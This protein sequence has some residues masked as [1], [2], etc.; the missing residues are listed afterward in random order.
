MELRAFAERVVLGTTLEEKLADPGIVTDVDPGFSSPGIHVPGRPQGLELQHLEGA[1]KPP[2]EHQ[3]NSDQ[4]RGILL[5]F[6]ANHEL[7][8]T[9]LMALV[10]LKFPQA[11]AAFRQG[12]FETLKEE[13]A[14]TRLYLDRMQAC[15]VSFGALPLSG[16]FWRAVEPMESPLDFVARLSLTFEQANLDYS[17]YYAERFREAGDRETAAIL[18]AIYR[19]E[20][21]HVGH[22]LKWFRKWKNQSD[23]DWDAYRKVMHFPLSPARAKATHGDYNREGRLAA[24]LEADFI[25]QLNLY[26]QSRGRKPDVYWFHPGAEEELLGAGANATLDQVARDLESLMLPLAR[27]EDVVLMRQMPSTD[28]QQRYID[29]GLS[30]PELL[31]LT[32]DL[33][34]HPLCARKIGTFRPWA[35]TPSSEGTACALNADYKTP[36]HSSA[37][38]G[39]SW[40]THQLRAWLEEEKPGYFGGPE[41][42]GTFVHT[43]AEVDAALASLAARPCTSAIAKAELGTSGRGQRRLS[44]V[45]G[46]TPHDRAWLCTALERQ[47]GILIEPELDRLLDITL[48]WDTDPMRF[49][50][51]TRQLVTA[52][53]RYAG[54]VLG[55]PFADCPVELKRFLLA[56]GYRVLHELVD[57]LQARLEGALTSLGHRGTFGVDAMV[58]RDAAGALRIKPVV[59]INPRQTMGQVALR[60]EQH[61]AAGRT[62]H[63]RLLT[64]VQLRQ[65]EFDSFEAF[66][67]T[68]QREHPPVLHRDGRLASGVLVLADAAVSRVLL[69]VLIVGETFDQLSLPP[70]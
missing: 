22:G 57:W 3:L 56:D 30:L 39:K 18:D 5:H 43:V 7:L 46:L 12:I 51:W 2:G 41:T 48:Q 32:D 58:Y 70:V 50:G 25:D 62:G 6:L 13:Q 61:L 66:A 9:E 65:G 67:L 31:P 59:E 15:G 69:P 60:L 63:F 33:S 19:D 36:P 55:Q 45:E 49:L 53:R 40:S 14:H 29:A 38:F 35:W 8:A 10:L 1:P 26:R 24:G 20:I 47:P 37:A 68:M 42:C 44:C 54:T 52:G 21:G 27:H 17:R 28:F 11:P 4:D 64:A 34:G 16:Y 23:T